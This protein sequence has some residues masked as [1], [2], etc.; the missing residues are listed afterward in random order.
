MKDAG[1][2]RLFREAI[3][4]IDSGNEVALQKLLDDCPRLAKDRLYKP[5]KWLRSKIANALK[6]FF[7]DP[8]L[9]WFVAEDPVRN[10]QLPPNIGQLA[11]IIIEKATQQQG[12]HLQEQLDYG[13]RLVAWSW[14][15]R[16]CNV[17]IVLLDVFIDAGA[18]VSSVANDALVNGNFRAAEHLINRGASLDLS[19]ALCLGKWSEADQLAI[20]ATDKEKQ[21]ALVLASLKG[22]TEAVKKALAYGAAINLPSQDLYSHAGPLHHAVSSRSLE[23]VKVLVEAGA[24]MNNRDKAYDGTPLGWARYGK[25][26]DIAEFLEK[27]GGTE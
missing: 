14:V 3:A 10:N 12:N 6:S 27:N 21:M 1:F 4:A 23:T 18:A 19:T 11:K 8:Y 24:Q 7:Q 25:M 2:Q 26:K 15:A 13:I 22:R 20:N 16:E 17:D 9:L 5:G